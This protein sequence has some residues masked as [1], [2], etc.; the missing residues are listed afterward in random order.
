MVRGAWETTWNSSGADLPMPSA[1]RVA[2][3][4]LTP[5]PTA[6]IKNRD[7]YRISNLRT[8]GILTLSL[9]LEQS[10]E[11]EQHDAQRQGRIR[12]IEGRPMIVADMDVEKVE[13]GAEADAV[14]HVA[15]RPADDEAKPDGRRQAIQ[16]E[17][18][19]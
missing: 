1:W 6:R 9:A 8:G 13:H 18:P 14:D 3:Q 17:Q 11:N 19:G 15:E 10:V 7:P 16:A 5:T 4:P 12:K 2:S